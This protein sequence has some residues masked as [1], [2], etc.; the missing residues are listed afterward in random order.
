MISKIVYK[1]ISDYADNNNA[2]ILYNMVNETDDKLL[3][4]SAIKK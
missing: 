2:D 1:R 4:F 3:N